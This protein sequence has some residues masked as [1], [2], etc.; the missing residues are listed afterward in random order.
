M[1]KERGLD[2][3]ERYVAGNPVS[4]DVRG[5]SIVVQPYILDPAEFG[6]G[7]SYVDPI[8]PIDPPPADLRWQADGGWVE[9]ASFAG[10]AMRLDEHGVQLATE[11]VH[12]ELELAALF[13]AYSNVG[14]PYWSYRFGLYQPGEFEARFGLPRDGGRPYL[15]DATLVFWTWSNSFQRQHLGGMNELRW[16]LR[17]LEWASRQLSR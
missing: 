3:L 10:L 14:L 13:L 6:D 16:N 11:A 9:L 5:G 2:N 7:S 12:R 1:A 8:L 17:S 15:D 4:F